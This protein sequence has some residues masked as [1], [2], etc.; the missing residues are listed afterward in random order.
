MKVMGELK[1]ISGPFIADEHGL[2]IW[3]KDANGN[4]VHF[5][6][7]RGWGHLT[8]GASLNLPQAE[9]IQEQR[10]WQ[11]FVAMA[12]N[13]TRVATRHPSRKDDI[14]RAAL[15][16][17]VLAYDNACPGEKWNKHER[18]RAALAAFVRQRNKA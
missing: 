5:L 8:G 15:D 17:A 3:G 6:D 2:M 11:T 7:I 13:Q 18:M 1:H 14:E 12:L 16:E 9:A 4:N 10:E